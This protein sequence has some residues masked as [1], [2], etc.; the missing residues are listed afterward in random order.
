MPAGSADQG[1]RYLK[2]ISSLEGDPIVRLK[3]VKVCFGSIVS[4][5]GVDFQVGKNEVVGL[6]GNNGAGKSTLIKTILGLHPRT[7]GEV[8]V[9]GRRVNFTS[10]R[11]ARAAG[12]ETVFQ[13]LSLAEDL[14]VVQNFFI[15][16]ELCRGGTGL[17]FQDAGRM[18][19]IAEDVLRELGLR[20]PITMQTRVSSL[21]GGER[22][23]VAIGRAFFFARTLLVLDEPTSALSESAVQH[24]REMVKRAKVRGVSVIFATHNATEVF[25]VADRFVILDNGKVYASLKKGTT[26]LTELEKLLISRKLSA[27][28]EMAAGVAHQ[29]RNPLGVL[30][31]SVELM[32][33]KLACTDAGGDLDDI[34]KVML[35]EIDSLNHVISNFV[36]FAHQRAPMKTPCSILEVI[37]ESLSSLTISS[38]PD[39]DVT[40]EVSEG[41]GLYPMDANLMKQALCILLMNAI[42][43]SCRNGPIEIKA[44]LKGGYLCVEVRDWGA[45]IAEDQR[46]KIF[47]PFFTTKPLG[48][49]LGLSIAHRILEQHNGT[50]NVFSS[51][52]KGATFQLIL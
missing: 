16:R 37:K 8:L 25:E 14:S 32:R 19:K 45:G 50:I 9:E 10:P 3:G 39:I 30:K 36:D 52:G 35:D 15:G 4:L 7:S 33:K 24:L 41:L 48:T 6:L 31:V 34:T 43:A 46:S 27:V 2:N 44:S 42:D 1:V 49:G 47:M 11:E 20:K 26:D 23:L 22:Q 5:D 40:V 12:I 17:G 29:V 51:P 13:D 18:E 38:F 21:S 28:K